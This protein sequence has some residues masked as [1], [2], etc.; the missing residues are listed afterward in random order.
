M[1]K[2]L[3]TLF[4]FTLASI[5]FSSC[6]GDDGRPEITETSVEFTFSTSSLKGVAA[7]GLTH[8]VITIED[9]LGNIVLDNE[10]VEIY[11]MNGNYISKPV[12]LL[13]GNYKLTAFLVL[14]SENNVVFAAPVEGSD[15]AYLVQ[16][17]LPIQ[18]EA[19]KD[20]V[21]KVNPEVVSTAESHPENFGY[22]SFG[23]NIAQTFDFLVGAFIYNDETANFELTTGEIAIYSG[24]T[25]VYSGELQANTDFTPDN[26]DPLGVTNKITLPEAYDNYTVNISKSGYIS[27]SQEFTKE[28]LRLYYRNE[29]NGPLVVVLDAGI[30]IPGLVAYYPFNGNANDESGNGNHGTDYGVADYLSSNFTF[31]RTFSNEP[32]IGPDVNDYVTVPNVLNSDEFSINFWVNSQYDQMHQMLMYL[33]E[34][35]DWTRSN[36][37]IDIVYPDMKLGVFINGLDLRTSDYSHEALLNGD[38]NDVFLNSASLELNK[39]YNITC[40]FNNSEITLYVDGVEYAKYLNVNTVVGNPDADILLGVCTYPTPGYYYYP[41]IGQLDELRFYDRALSGQEVSLLY[42]L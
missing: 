30:N 35:N 21:S 9:P 25:L 8:V 36:F 28:E 7:E 4:I 18:F 40:T 16:E 1:K 20:V 38:Y 17:P 6:R 14:N 5:I 15:K 27:Y 24:E 33:S 3:T 22:A 26:Y 19:V 32:G 39:Y 37:F 10:K 29:D 12:S 13:T 2:I 31:A 42:D 11:N 23:F 34:S 41:L